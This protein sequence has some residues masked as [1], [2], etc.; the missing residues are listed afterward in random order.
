MFQI[1]SSVRDPE[2]WKK[3]DRKKKQDESNYWQFSKN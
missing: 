2:G 3:N 1:H